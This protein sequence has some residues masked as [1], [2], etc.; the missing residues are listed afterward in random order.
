MVFS[1]AIALFDILLVLLAGSVLLWF[2]HRFFY[3]ALIRPLLR[4]RRMEH[5][6]MDRLI[7]DAARGDT[8]NRID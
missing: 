1:G 5:S 7:R 2:A 4:K 8:D 6:R 3:K